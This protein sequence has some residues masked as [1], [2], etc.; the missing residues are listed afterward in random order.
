[1]I[2]RWLGPKHYLS[3]W[4]R[5]GLDPRVPRA[6]QAFFSGLL[7]PCDA[8]IAAYDEGVVGFLRVSTDVNRSGEKRLYAAGTWVAVEYRGG[9]IARTL[10]AR[11]M[12][13][14][15]P[16]TV[17]VRTIS[18]EGRGFVGSLVKWYPQ[19]AFKVTA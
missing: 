8:T 5:D 9:D 15:E 7:S 3:V 2:Y 12:A 10:W 16:D 13:K 18:P 14:H 11:A 17:V 19:V 4:A 1:M 6:A